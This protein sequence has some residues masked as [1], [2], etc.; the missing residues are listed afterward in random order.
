MGKLSKHAILLVLSLLIFTLFIGYSNKQNSKNT[1]D[2]EE[3]TSEIKVKGYAFEL[4]DVEKD[5]LPTTRKRMIIGKEAIN[6]YLYK[7]NNEMENDAK[8][9]DN[10]GCEYSN[11][12]KSINVSWVSYPYFY[13]KG[14]IIIQYVGENEKIIS[15]LNDILGEQ[16]AGYK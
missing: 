6:I 12:T 10:D 7:S 1:F 15:D 11:G 5:F 2:I 3:F 14:N 4:K 16:F 9:I 8:R 13:K